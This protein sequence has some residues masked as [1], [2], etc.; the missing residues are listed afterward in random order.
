MIPPFGKYLM[1]QVGLEPTNGRFFSPYTAFYAG[2][3]QVI[4]T[5]IN[6]ILTLLFTNTK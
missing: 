4:L 6:S 1:T 3:H 2:F 5:Y